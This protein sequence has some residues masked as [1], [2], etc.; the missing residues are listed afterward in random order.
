MEKKTLTYWQRKEIVER[1]ANIA[2]IRIRASSEEED[3]TKK[4][5]DDMKEFI[6]QERNKI[7]GL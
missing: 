4:I 7:L 2:T 6:R 5:F 1:A 3:P